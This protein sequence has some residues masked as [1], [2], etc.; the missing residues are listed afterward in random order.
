MRKPVIRNQS[1]K[2]SKNIDPQSIQRAQA[3]LQQFVQNL[4]SSGSLEKAAA[5]TAK[6]T[7]TRVET[8]PA[9]NKDKK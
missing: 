9:E 3:V 5:A 1:L 4:R 8:K 6:D 2:V 7:G